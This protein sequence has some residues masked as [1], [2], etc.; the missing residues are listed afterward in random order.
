MKELGGWNPLLSASTLAS[1][2][3][4]MLKFDH[5]KDGDIGYIPENGF[6]R[7][8]QSK[9]ATKY[10]LWLEQ[11]ECRKLQHKLRGG[12]KQITRADGRSYFVDAYDKEKNEIIEV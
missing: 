7:R 8:R 12:E 4:H 11:K 1:F 10:I 6:P 9:L 5:I 3:M 2:V